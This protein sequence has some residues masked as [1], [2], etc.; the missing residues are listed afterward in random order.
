MS[1]ATQ[2]LDINDDLG[3]RLLQEAAV[4]APSHVKTAQ[5][6]TREKLAELPT[7]CF[8]IHA[9]TK[10]GSRLRRFPIHTPQDTWLSQAYF[11]KNAHKMPRTAATIAA[12]HIKTACEKFQIDV[13]KTVEMLASEERPMSNL[14]V[15][16]NDMRKTASPLTFGEAVD[17]EHYA[18]KNKYPLHNPGYVKKAA[19]YF[20]DY[21]GQ[22]SPEDR[23]EY[24][25]KVLER[26]EAFDVTLQGDELALLNKTANASYGDKL[27]SELRARMIYVDGVQQAEQDLS[28]IASAQEKISADK[29][30]TLLREWDRQY[31]VDKLY[32]KSISDA[33]EATHGNFFEKE[34]GFTWEDT[35][36]GM[37][38]S[39]KELEKA[40]SEKFDKIKG[41]FGATLADSF[42]KHA[43]E[44]FSSLPNDAQ[45]V[46][47]KI[48]KGEL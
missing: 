3:Y 13:T 1:L 8:A 27:K 32:G 5:V 20:V 18:L 4:R 30:S 46:I 21:F 10:E 28:K 11:E 24:A 12:T 47:A 36:S 17:G 25:T 19:A 34:S 42:K 37:T 14:Y 44:I 43:S 22:F 39:G 2:I 15:E 35:T 45:I 7:E 31:G 48:A 23:K 6:T 9:L 16:E 33:F 40:A 41:Y 29:F 26:A 38:V